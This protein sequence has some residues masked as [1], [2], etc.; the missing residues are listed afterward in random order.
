MIKDTKK[1]PDASFT[2]VWSL[3]EYTSPWAGFEINTL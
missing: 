3:I 2:Y 1:G